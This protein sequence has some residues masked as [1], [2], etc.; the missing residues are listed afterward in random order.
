MPTAT[1][2]EYIE[3]IYKASRQG[4]ARASDVADAMGVSRPTVTATLRRLAAR[5]LV[6]RPKGLIELTPDGEREA[7]SILRRHR[8]AERFLVD[9]LGLPW[10]EVHEEA[11]LLEH[12]LSPRVQDAL[13]SFLEN[14]ESCPHGH[15]IPTSELEMAA[16]TGH[17]LSEVTEGDRV[18]IARISEADDDILAGAGEAGLFP[19][20]E[21]VVESSS[22]GIVSLVLESGTVVTVD[23]ALAGHVIVDKLA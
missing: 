14:P 8:L 17:P 18:R 22:A 19:G 10:D 7:L 16:A 23:G 4:P 21:A 15:P 11:C 6:T 12:A 13:E 1:L 9:T 3:A 20:T 5:G 2:E